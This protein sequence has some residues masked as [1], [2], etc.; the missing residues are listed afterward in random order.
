M[1][2]LLTHFPPETANNL[3][4]DAKETEQKLAE[5]ER[6]LNELR[7]LS[8]SRSKKKVDSMRRGGSLMSDNYISPPRQLQIPTEPR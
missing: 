7:E 8:A 6:L 3:L 1:A 4:A 2:E 5:D